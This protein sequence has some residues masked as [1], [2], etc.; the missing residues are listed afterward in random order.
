MCSVNASWLGSL[1]WFSS[2]R[3]CNG[4]SLN[5]LLHYEC[6]LVKEDAVFSP[7][8]VTSSAAWQAGKH[9]MEPRDIFSTTSNL[10]NFTLQK[11]SLMDKMQKFGPVKISPWNDYRLWATSEQ[12]KP[13]TAILFAAP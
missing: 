4:A 12:I 11:C 5:A 9:V 1:A 3:L 10:K 8:P 2:V 6:Q 13:R 7:L